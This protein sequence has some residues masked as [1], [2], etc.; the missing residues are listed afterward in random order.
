MIRIIK[1]LLILLLLNITLLTQGESIVSVKIENNKIVALFKIPAQHHQILQ[2]DFFYLKVDKFE[3][4]I[5]NETIYPKGDK[6]ES[7]AIEYHNKVILS[8]TFE[9]EPNY[10]QSFVNITTGYQ[11]CK[12][13][14]MCLFP[15]QEKFKLEIKD[16]TNL[17]NSQE[18]AKENAS[19][20][21]TIKFLFMAFIGGLILNFMP[22][23]LPVL[24][25]KAMSL[26]N[27]SGQNKIEIFKHSLV[28]S[29]GVLVSFL[30]LAIFV[31]F[32][33][34]SG[35]L[36]GWGFQFQNPYFVAILLS[37]IFTFALSLFGVFEIPGLGMQM[38]NKA[39]SKNGLTGAFFSGVFAVL[40]A[41]PCTAPM[42]GPALGFAFVQNSGLIIL[43]FLAIGLGLA[44]P[45]LLIGVYPKIIDF[46]PKPGNWMNTFKHLM[47]FLLLGTTIYLMR[48]LIVHI[49][50]INVLTYC[51]FL[52]FAMWIYGKWGS[53]VNSKIRR[54][55]T[56]II[57]HIIF[58]LSWNLFMNF[59]SSQDNSTSS[60]N[61]TNWLTFSPQLIEKLREDK[62]IIFL[63]FSAKW[64][65]TCQTNELL[66]LNTDEIQQAFKNKN[67]TLVLGDYTKKNLT[68]TK[69]LQKFNRAG[70]PLYAFYLPSKKD[71]I[72]LP[73][74][75]TKQM[76]YDVLNEIQ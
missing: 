24:S 27:Q 56:L 8:K 34:T 71:P 22:C 11:L 75:I 76:I 51:L 13:N 42:L 1:Y 50:A 41:T 65:A 3:G 49:D 2:K 60:Q 7:G 47:G 52:T 67:V 18:K 30:I 53:P 16:N 32:L 12:D 33:K 28:Y 31:V 23:V 25:I 37:L 9:L 58:V 54:I 59:D 63:D 70:V 5:L 17:R 48:V 61:H 55:V 26:V 6:P 20:F 43:F 73:E 57:M 62:K 21:T 68:I 72:I 38:A 15:I 66:V 14:G 69:Y 44:F 36:V 74:I 29:V 10:K 40:L 35:E 39:S 4:I 64:C 19:I 46:F 45:F